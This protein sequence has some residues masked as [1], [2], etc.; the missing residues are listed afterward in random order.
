MS[1]DDDE[2][3]WLRGTELL[4]LKIK[5]QN[6]MLLYTCDQFSEG[7]QVTYNVYSVNIT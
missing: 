2:T 5:I 7:T 6:M 1:D 3:K 4:D